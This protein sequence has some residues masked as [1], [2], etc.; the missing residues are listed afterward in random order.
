MELINKNMVNEIVGTISDKVDEGTKKA[1]NLKKFEL[2][3]QI[4][5]DIHGISGGFDDY[6]YVEFKK[7]LLKQM[8]FTL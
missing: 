1:T 4:A 5:D 6:E 8:G 3:S 2:A 7:K